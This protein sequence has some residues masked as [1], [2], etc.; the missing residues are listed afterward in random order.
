MGA[1]AT[2]IPFLGSLLDKLLPDPQAKAAAQIELA[3][4][5]QTGELAALQAETDLARGQVAINQV[6][7]ASTRLF[8]AGWRPFVGWVC[9]F[10]V[11]FK[12]VAGPLLA[13]LLQAVGHPVELPQLDADELWPVLLGM[14]GLGGLRTVEKVKRAA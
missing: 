7:A 5:V 2:L 6:E 10:T 13:M 11:A 3:R 9:G 4:M 8:V 14:L 1:L 12:Y